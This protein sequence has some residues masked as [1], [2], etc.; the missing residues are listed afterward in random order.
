[1]GS[2]VLTSDQVFS[3]S[4]F[5]Y[6]FHETEFREQKMVSSNP[7]IIACK[8]VYTSTGTGMIIP[9]YTLWPS[10]LLNHFWDQKVSAIAFTTIKF[11]IS[12][13]VL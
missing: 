1:M 13:L 6:G 2:L 4:R 10:A 12:S 7:Y 11:I 3:E 8:N 5:Q 9:A